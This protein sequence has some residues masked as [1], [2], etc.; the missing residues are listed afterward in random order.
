MT[1][2]EQAIIA[3]KSNISV[4]EIALERSRS[5]LRDLQH[6]ANEPAMYADSIFSGVEVL[7]DLKVCTGHIAHLERQIKRDEKEIFKYKL[8]HGEVGV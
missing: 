6:R 7:R 3:L 4:N 2:Q 5:W 8:N 1:K